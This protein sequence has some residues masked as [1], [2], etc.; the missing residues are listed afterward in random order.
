MFWSAEESG[1]VLMARLDGG[2]GVEAGELEG[3]EAR[4]WGKW[5]KGRW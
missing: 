4:L 5:K 2:N 3:S 1:R